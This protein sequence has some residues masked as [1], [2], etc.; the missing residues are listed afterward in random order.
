MNKS[1][2]F[3]L[4]VFSCC[5]GFLTIIF[6]VNTSAQFDSR[7]IPTTPKAQN[8]PVKTQIAPVYAFG[9][10]VIIPQAG[11]SLSR[12]N[13]GVFGTISTSHITPGNVVTLWWAIF[14]NPRACAGATCAPSDLN[15][16]AVYGSL[17]YGGGYLVGI[18]GRA[19][20]GG[21]LGVGD[22]TGFHFLPM[23]PNM[24]NPAP[25]LVDPK[26]AE[27]HLVIRDHGPASSDP[28]T[29]QQQLTTFGTGTNIQAAI[30][31]P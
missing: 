11:A 5:V 22:N 2:F 14:N 31:K 26:G 28:G 29:L 21:Y 25:G 30:F 27:I 3:R 7:I 13:E 8:N 18:N 16:P 17:Q 6:P 23:F 9:S 20:F 1:I 24:P 15:N 12:S 19:D 10:T 4:L